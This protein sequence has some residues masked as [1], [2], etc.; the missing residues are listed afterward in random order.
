[1]RIYGHYNWLNGEQKELD[2]SKV[3]VRHVSPSFG[4]AHMVYQN[5]RLQLDAFVMFN[6]QFEFNDLAPSQQSR[7]Y[8]YALDKNGN[9]Y[10]PRW[11][12]M[13]LRSSYKINEG[14]TATA[15]LENITDQRYRTYSSGIAAA[16]RN[17]ILS[18][19]YVF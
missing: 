15:I 16:G 3:A 4:D 17:L 5:D 6:G 18:L 1:V 14:L 11:Y 2:G 13:N 8:L 12:T 19:R 7:P 9:P 10:S